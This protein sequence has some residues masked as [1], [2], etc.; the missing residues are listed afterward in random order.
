MRLRDALFRARGRRR[1]GRWPGFKA[2]REPQAVGP[3]DDPD[4]LQPS[5]QG[6]GSLGDR[7]ES[8]DAGRQGGIALTGPRFSPMSR[9]GRVGGGIEIVAERRAERRL[10]AL[11]DGDLVEGGRP[12]VRRSGR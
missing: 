5:L 12:Q 10:V 11:L 6:R 7:G 2:S 1:G 8:H 9:R 4:L 3:A